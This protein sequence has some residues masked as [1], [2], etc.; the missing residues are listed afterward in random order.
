LSDGTCLSRRN[1]VY[2]SLLLTRSSA[3]I[4]QCNEEQRHETEK[5]EAVGGYNRLDL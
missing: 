2:G 1:N 3:T 4:S 5:S